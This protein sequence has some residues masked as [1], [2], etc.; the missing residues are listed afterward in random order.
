MYPRAFDYHRANSLTEAISLLSQLG[1]ESRVIAGGQ[2]LIPLMKLRFASPAHLIDLNFIPNLAFV[3]QG[4]GTLRFGPLARH[5]QIADSDV[6]RNIPILHDCAAG[7]ADAQVRNQGTIGGSLAEADPSGDWGPVLITLDAQL[8]CLGLK[9]ERTIPAREFFVDAYT[10]ALAH[11]ELIKEITLRI[12]GKGSGGAYIASKRCPQVYASASVAV[13]LS[14]RDG[15]CQEAAIALGAVGLTA[16]RPAEAEAELRGKALNDGVIQTAAEAA[17]AATDPQP[18]MRG[19][20]DYKRVL[21]AA[22]LREAIIVAV[23]RSRGE[24]VEVSHH[25]A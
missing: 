14:L 3:E 20:A 25:Y 24:A 10:T 4:V 13:Q 17:T 11:D 8:H 2:S 6:I 16:I 23:R 7:I 12:P 21:I 9:G 22:L 5:T 18:D 1:P 19:S 15:V